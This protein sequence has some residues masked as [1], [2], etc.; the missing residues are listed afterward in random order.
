MSNVETEGFSELTLAEIA[1]WQVRV[2][3]VD[4]VIVADLPALQRGAVWKPRQV[5]TLWDSLVR[6]FP[7]GSF[8]ISPLGDG[9]H[10]SQRMAYASQNDD[11]TRTHYLLDGQQRANAI[12][13]G[14]IDPLEHHDQISYLWL[15]LLPP[16][17]KSDER[18]F[19]FRVINKFHPWGFNRNNPENRMSVGQIRDAFTKL[20][21]IAEELGVKTENKSPY[22][23]P[24]NL[25]WPWDAKAPIP[26]SFIMKSES[27]ADVLAQLERLPYWR[28]KHLL[29][30]RSTVL[31][32]ICGQNEVGKQRLKYA[33]QRFKQLGNLKVPILTVPIDSVIPE[34]VSQIFD[35]RPDHIETLFVRVNSSGT[36]LEGEELIYSL[37]KSEWP[38]S[39]KIMEDIS[40]KLA[41]PAKTVVLAARLVLARRA[42]HNTSLGKMP[43]DLNVPSFRRLLRGADNERPNF[44]AQLDRALHDAESTSGI[45]SIF[46]KL[47]TLIAID[48]QST[49]TDDGDFRLHPFLASD[50]ARGKDGQN[51]MLLLLRW[52]DR[53]L[54]AGIDPN[55]IDE[56]DRRRTLGFI[57]A[58]SWLGL[59]ITRCVN[60]LWVE[61]ETC[62]VEELARFFNSQKFTS[63]LRRDEE[64][65]VILIP[66]IP[67]AVFCT[68]L[69][70]L[71][72][73]INSQLADRKSGYWTRQDYYRNECINDLDDWIH[74]VVHPLWSVENH[75]DIGAWWLDRIMANRKLVV[76][77]QRNSLCRWFPGYD[78]TVP[79]AEDTNRPW[80]YDHIHPDNYVASRKK[81]PQLLRTLHWSNGNSRAWP[82]EA[83]RSAQDAAPQSK[84][85]AASDS[86]KRYRITD[87]NLTAESFITDNEELIC[88]LKSVPISLVGNNRNYL[89]EAEEYKDS[90]LALVTAITL[91]LG[92]IYNEWFESLAISELLPNEFVETK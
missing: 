60:R 9:R 37:F 34:C 18:E 78:P 38:G 1:S 83:N 7:I 26:V 65:G 5:E 74:R 43:P 4:P 48:P 68:S 30:W 54:E 24:L 28:S 87:Q 3:S 59:D 89:A 86:E 11:R 81:I 40:H 25:A 82:L 85:S 61:L 36:V 46:K 17:N 51:L 80:D 14:F 91:R 12:A 45:K 10:G 63:L 50:L 70:N 67:G 56:V 53:M 69:K 23:F 35:E 58:V 64:D 19:V 15:D 22:H 6:G 76:Y 41:T 92:R 32:I 84:L 42:S 29:E 55:A 62:K 79:G 8:L 39:T 31:D 57:T 47:H 88:W 21:D 66:P 77:A 90:H 52:V 16:D 75:E 33:V 49:T 20:Q 13:L 27:E 2:H 44:R 73:I 71:L 72:E